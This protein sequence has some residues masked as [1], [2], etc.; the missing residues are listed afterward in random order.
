MEEPKD[1]SSK[2]L[3]GGNSLHNPGVSQVLFK[4]DG[5][6]LQ[7]HSVYQRLFSPRQCNSLSLKWSLHMEGIG[8]SIDSTNSS[9]GD[10]RKMFRLR[11]RT[12]SALKNSHG[13]RQMFL[14]SFRV[15]CATVINYKQYWNWVFLLIT[16]C[17]CFRC[18]ILSVM[19]MWLYRICVIVFQVV[20]WY[21]VDWN[22]LGWV[23]I[24]RHLNK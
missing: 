3:F 14:S 12:C 19:C 15:K 1:T 11:R 4:R 21:T 13:F 24:I 7:I 8:Y 17:C 18:S 9:I 2:S 5:I 22:V 20:F 10:R 6:G 23:S 16:R